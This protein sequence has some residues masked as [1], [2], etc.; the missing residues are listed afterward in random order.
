[1]PESAVRAW[2]PGIPGIREVLH[3]RFLEHA[4]PSHTH[5]AWTVLIIDEGMVRYGLHR[6]EHG[7][8]RSQVTVLPPHVP[9]DGRNVTEWGFR[10]RVLYLE[11][12]AMDES[13][14]GAAVDQPGLR[15]P[16]LRKRIHE[17]HEVLRGPWEPWHAQ[18]RLALITE[19]LAERL[20]GAPAP[21]RVPVAPEL[22][23]QLRELLDASAPV[24]ITLDE[25]ARRL[26]AHPAHLVRVFS[27]RFGIPPHRYLTG[28]RIDLA[29]RLLLDGL[30]AA[31]VAL[32]AGFTDQSHLNRHFTAMLGTT[33]GRFRA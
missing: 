20:H 7:A 4:Y 2:E 14:I 32:A 15:D 23:G 12:S 30:P 25:A 13:L 18:S 10:K 16:L 6:G 17:L 33:P 5:A 21:E 27:T 11:P 24:G 28:L 26:H 8:L 1:M 3:A 22:A 29:R 31:Q 19:R 9:H